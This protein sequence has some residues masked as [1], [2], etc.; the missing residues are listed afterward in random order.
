VEK[1]ITRSSKRL[2]ELAWAMRDAPHDKK[3][4]RRLQDWYFKKYVPF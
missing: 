4:G 1:E 3:A 2:I